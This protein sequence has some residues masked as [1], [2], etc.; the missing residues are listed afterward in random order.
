MRDITV[1]IQVNGGERETVTVPSEMKTAEVLTELL[2]GFSLQATNGNGRRPDWKLT[3]KV[4]GRVLDPDRTL[5]ENGVRSGQDLMLG[6][7]ESKP[8]PAPLVCKH[9]GFE[10]DQLSQFCR[11]CGKPL[12]FI[13]PADLR[14]RV[15]MPDGKNQEVEVPEN[16][17]AK[18]LIAALLGPEAKPNEWKLYDKD[19][20]QDLDPNKN[21][22]ENGVRSG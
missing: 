14:F 17:T 2:E 19:T 13:V 10:N 5:E 22:A 20:S 3:E 18:E 11:K 6:S 21:L 4:T 8:V 16:F 15:Q 1:H 7:E 9:C 12:D